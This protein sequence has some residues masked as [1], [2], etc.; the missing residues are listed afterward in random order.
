MP[1]KAMIYAGYDVVLAAPDGTKRHI[2]PAS[3]SAR[4]FGGDEKA[5]QRS[6]ILRQRWVDEQR[7]YT[8]LDHW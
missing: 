7:P 5:Y 4:H 1:V 3:G 2:D 6:R 8:A